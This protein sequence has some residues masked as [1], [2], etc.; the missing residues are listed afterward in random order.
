M[1][2]LQLAR[3][4]DRDGEE[5]RN[6]HLLWIWNLHINYNRHRYWLHCSCISRLKQGWNL[7]RFI[8]CKDYKFLGT[9]LARVRV[10]QWSESWLEL[11]TQPTFLTTHTGTVLFY[12]KRNLVEGNWVSGCF[13]MF[14]LHSL[15]N[16]AFHWRTL[17]P[18]Y[19]QLFWCLC[20]KLDMGRHWLGNFHFYSCFWQGFF[21]WRTQNIYE[22]Q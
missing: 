10:C 17:H 22:Q 8:S 19:V 7:Y 2:I 16:S 12:A 13:M 9:K 15:V 11:W 14:T 21:F 3:Q 4:G 18:S 1:Y 5:G 20:V 6:L